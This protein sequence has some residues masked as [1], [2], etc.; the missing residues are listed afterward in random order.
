MRALTKVF[1][2]ILIVAFCLFASISSVE[3]LECTPDSPFGQIVEVRCMGSDVP[4]PNAGPC[5]FIGNDTGVCRL[6][7]D[8]LSDE[9]GYDV[10]NN[11][12]EVVVV[13]Q[14]KEECSPRNTDPIEPG[15]TLEGQTHTCTDPVNFLNLCLEKPN[16]DVTISNFRC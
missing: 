14:G 8:S 9:W 16:I 2:A 13:E 7:F 6:E 3:A 15:D 12:D 1:S 4:D 10:Q 11:T 5:T